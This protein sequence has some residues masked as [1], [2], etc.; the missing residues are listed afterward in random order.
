VEDLKIMSLPKTIAADESQHTPL[1][2]CGCFHKY[3]RTYIYV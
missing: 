3:L 1:K 2:G